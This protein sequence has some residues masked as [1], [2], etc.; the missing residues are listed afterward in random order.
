MRQE[1]SAF[2]E[3]EKIDNQWVP[4]SKF[5]SQN[6]IDLILTNGCFL[7]FVF[8]PDNVNLER[9]EQSEIFPSSCN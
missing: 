5:K 2:S 9:K 6:S 1:G 8:L 3:R 4:E 7:V